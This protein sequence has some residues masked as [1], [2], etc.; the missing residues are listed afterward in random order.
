MFDLGLERLE[1]LVRLPTISQQVAFREMQGRIGW[2]LS[3][4]ET[5]DQ[6]REMLVGWLQGIADEVGTQKV[7]LPGGL[8]G[9][10][11]WARVKGHDETAAVLLQGHYDVV[12]V[13]GTYQPYQQEGR[14]YGRGTTDMKGGVVAA[15][16]AVESL[17]REG[18]RPFVDTYLLF[19]CEEEV[20]A[21]GAM[22]VVAE[23][24][25]W[26]KKVKLA[27][28][29]EPG[30][31]HD[32]FEYSWGHP[33]IAGL[34]LTVPLPQTAGHGER[35]RVRIEP[36]LGLVDHASREPGSIDANG[37]MFSTLGQLR[38]GGVVSWYSDRSID[39]AINSTAAWAE[40]VVATDVGGHGVYE[41]AQRALNYH[42]E[43]VEE[44]ERINHLRH[45]TKIEVEQ[46]SGGG[47]VYDLGRFGDALAGLRARVATYTN[48]VYSRPPLTLAVVAVGEG[49]AR[50]K[51]DIRTD[52]ALRQDLPEMLAEL[53]PAP[54]QAE[55]MWNDPAFA[56]REV[57]ENRYFR[58]L[59]V[60]HRARRRVLVQGHTGWTEAAIWSTLL[61]IPTI[62]GGP[63]RM[64]VA[65]TI[66]EFIDLSH[67]GE[68]VGVL[69][70]FLRD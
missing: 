59:L 33:G 64:G 10:N 47:V 38:A 32:G 67:W 29:L 57:V 49:Q 19:T 35:W 37:I 2:R 11:V 22:K 55:L 27:I 36:G 34:S 41:A 15:I 25:T 52:N 30:Y 43:R 60:A 31:G 53:F 28:C 45:V 44:P 18:E 13:N 63:G 58:R 42:L 26:L 7:S 61:D 14:L 6:A 50:V 17:V 48:E 5:F 39:G 16:M 23:P 20:A 40:A 24:F 51:I 62:V 66:Q 69:V 3:Q 1:A 8:V 68:M 46:A 70:D 4:Q 21:G 65:H 56:G 54:M 12:E 9:Y